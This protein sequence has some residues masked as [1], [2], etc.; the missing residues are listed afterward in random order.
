MADLRAPLDFRPDHESRGVDEREHGQAVGIAQL[1]QSGGLVGIVRLDGAGHMLAVIGH[2]AER[3]ALDSDKPGNHARAEAGSQF[4]ERVAVRQGFDNLADIIGT[5]PIFRDQIA[6]QDLIL[7]FPFPRFSLEIR[8]VL[9]GSDDGRG[10][11]F[12]GDIHHAVGRLHIDRT[13]VARCETAQ[14]AALDHHRPPH[15]DVRI[16]RGNND[17]ATTQ[18]GRITGKTVTGDNAHQGNLAAQLGKQAEGGQIEPGNHDA[19]GV[20]IPGPSPSALGK[21]NQG[22]AL[23]IGQLEKPVHLFMIEVALG[24]GQ[25][26]IV[27][28]HDHAAGRLFTKLRRVDRSKPRDQAIGRRSGNEIVNRAPAA[29]GGY[30]ERAVFDKTALV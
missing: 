24:A 5:A 23:F 20:R 2:E 3:R 13:D 28:G 6:Q 1:H 11:V 30:V 19:L 8:D 29:L 7:R 25:H 15:A 18:E 17:I 14:A 12:H 26:R 16:P 22:C 4:E 27:V 9:L 10:F 21:E